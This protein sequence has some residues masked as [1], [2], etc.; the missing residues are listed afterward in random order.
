ME[1]FSKISSV[2]HTFPLIK[3]FPESN[4]SKPNNKLISVVFPLPLS[5][6]IKYFLFS[7]NSA[8]KFLINCFSLYE[9]QTLSNTILEILS[10]LLFFI[11]AFIV[12]IYGRIEFITGF[13]AIKFWILIDIDII[14]QLN[15][16]TNP[17]AA[18]NS[19]AVNSPLKTKYVEKIT[20]MKKE[21]YDN[22]IDK[23]LESDEIFLIL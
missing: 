22:I 23:V 7:L 9:K 3:I 21:K 2:S 20:T 5:P 17:I 19:P 18:K 1:I 10:V 4:F 14:G 16:S 11:L 6:F 13:A 15:W 8:L 12:F